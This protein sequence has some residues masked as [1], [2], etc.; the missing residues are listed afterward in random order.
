MTVIAISEIIQR[1]ILERIVK[2]KLLKNK[3]MKMNLLKNVSIKQKLIMGFLIIA[4]LIGVVGTL[5][6]LA[7]KTVNNNGKEITDNKLVSMDKVSY[8]RQNLLETRINIINLLDES[9]K[10]RLEEY[11]DNI[12][13][14][15]IINDSNYVEYEKIPKKTVEEEKI[16]KDEI[17]P[18][19]G[20][21]KA[22][23]EKIME[24]AKNNNY[25]EAKRT[26]DYE[27]LNQ[28]KILEGASSKIIQINLKESEEL[29][30]NNESIYNKSFYFMI[31]IILLGVIISIVVGL[32]I[33]KNID[34]RLKNVIKFVGDFE[35]GD[36]TQTLE[37][38]SKDEIGLVETSINRAME[39]VRNLIKEIN[40]GAEEVGATS[41][42]LSV[43]LKEVSSKMEFVNEATAGI[44]RGTEEVSSS[45]EEISASMEEIGA[46]TAELANK[47]KEGNDTSKAI[48]NRAMEVKKNGI[49]SKEQ[50]K[51]IYEEKFSKVKEAIEDGKVVEQIT[52][53]TESIG[54]IA[55]QTNLLALNAAIEAARAG[56][57]GRG[58]AVVAEEVRKL[59][60]QSSETVASIQQV[61]NKVRIAFNNLSSS[62][63]ETLE[64]IDKNVMKDYETLV[65]TGNQYEEDAKLLYTMA[66][67]IAMATNEMASTIDQVNLAIQNVSATTEEAAS[68]SEEILGGVNESTIAIEEIAKS[69][70][71][72]AEL[73][74]RLNELIKE[75]KV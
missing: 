55:E 37:I 72:Q 26:Y 14:L 56:E 62:A 43:T 9:H 27:F 35:N 73:A 11:L 45:T 54:S 42:E 75:F 10:G 34:K 40:V 46:T 53:M 38:T 15:T 60:E 25:A 30:V 64:Y 29:K 6:T 67:E 4:L 1:T 66:E 49:K 3:S 17:T 65:E 31:I 74:E 22:S 48:Q 20:Q 2:M 47:A 8:I 28:S 68:S 5:G 59:A 50:S 44:A 69:A 70:Q 23:M 57:Q 16:Y 13:S 12:A 51:V 41:E 63:E 32:Y 7:L 61:V 18:A 71:D 58:F 24:Y 33:A 36:L 19:L 39:S 52:L 21:Y